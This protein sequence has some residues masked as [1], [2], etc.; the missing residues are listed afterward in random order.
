MKRWESPRRE[1][2]ND[3]GKGGSARQ[4]QRRKQFKALRQRLKN[5]SNNH[6][7]QQNNNQGGSARLPLFCFIDSGIR[8]EETKRMCS[9]LPC[10]A[11]VAYRSLVT[12]FS[13]CRTRAM[14]MG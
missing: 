12:R 1:G 10:F 11:V 2:R 8:L 14:G 13:A 5:Q 6:S 4:R 9:F 3:K 7:N